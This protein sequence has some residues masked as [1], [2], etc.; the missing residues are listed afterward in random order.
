[1]QPSENGK[2]HNFRPNLGPQ[3]FCSWI[4]PFLRQ[5]RKLSSYA[6]SRETNEPNLK[7][8]LKKPLTLGL[9][10]VSFGPTLGLQIFFA[11]FT[12]TSN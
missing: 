3:K 6:I 4:L 11:S 1:M 10:L 12:S 5:C 8:G 9:I 2:N 7:K